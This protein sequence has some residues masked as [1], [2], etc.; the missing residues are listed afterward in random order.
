MGRLG[1]GRRTSPCVPSHRELNHRAPPA[2]AGTGPAG[3]GR[4]RGGRDPVPRLPAV[5]CR[6]RPGRRAPGRRRRRR[7]PNRCSRRLWRAARAHALLLPVRHSGRL[8]VC[9]R[10]WECRR[11]LWRIPQAAPAYRAPRG[12]V[13]HAALLF[14]CLLFCT[15]PSPQPWLAR[16]VQGY[17]YLQHGLQTAAV[18][19]WL[20]DWAALIFI[21]R[22]WGAPPGGSDSGSSGSGDSEAG[23]GQERSS[24]QQEP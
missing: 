17:E 4:R 14:R 8:C 2:H 15:S 9:E 10:V 6:Q 5:C 12:P 19:H 7:R 3:A 18:T 1:S 11:D 21:I 13:H 24:S 23:V 20:Y 16:C 22:V